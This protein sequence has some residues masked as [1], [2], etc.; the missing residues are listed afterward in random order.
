MPSNSS[1]VQAHHLDE[2]KK[3][4]HEQRLMNYALLP[5]HIAVE[6]LNLQTSTIEKIHRQIRNEEHVLLVFPLN[7]E[8]IVVSSEFH[9]HNLVS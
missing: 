6:K 7:L 1:I 3:I 5:H 4:D 9:N 8:Y 2:D